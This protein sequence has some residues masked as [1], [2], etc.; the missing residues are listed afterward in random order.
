V[1]SL[2]LPRDLVRGLPQGGRRG[3]GSDGDRG[4]GDA[5]MKPAAPPK[6]RSRL[7]PLSIRD[8]ELMSPGQRQRREAAE[9]AEYREWLDQQGRPTPTE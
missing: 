7:K 8:Y 5:Q 3:T 1:V 2:E 9:Q 6:F 4:A